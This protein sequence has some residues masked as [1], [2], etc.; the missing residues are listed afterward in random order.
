MSRKV[1]D[2]KECDYSIHTHVHLGKTKDDVPGGW[3]LNLMDIREFIPVLRYEFECYIQINGII[4][5]CRVRINPRLFYSGVSLKN[6]LREQR[7]LDKERLLP[8]ELKF[9]KK[10]LDKFLND[11]DKE[12]LDYID[13]KLSVGKSYSS[14]GWGLSKD[15]VS[16]IFPVDAY[17][18]MFPVYIDGIPAETRINLQT[19]LFYS[20]KELSEELERLNKI[21]PKQKVDARIIL[22]E[23]YL[24]LLKSFKKGH[25]SDYNCV[26]CGTPLDKDSKS[27]KCFDCLDKELTVLKLKKILEFFNP[28]E[29]F[30]EEDLLELGY[31][32]G[33]IKIFVYKF[34]KNDLITINWD[35]SFQLKDEST[36][37]DFIRKWK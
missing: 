1:L 3:A 23:N 8:L 35:E 13:T 4:S 14:K 29:T 12:D 2:E 31:T 24:K 9:N 20:S 37:N 34:E 32:K 36:L 33:Q 21:D 25:Y 10:D 27:N 26:I 28:L 17:N 5:P 18:Y 15:V 6:Y 16:K 11:F 22:N 19:R 7:K 30:Y